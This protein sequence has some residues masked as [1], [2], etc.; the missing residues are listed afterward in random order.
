ML[1]LFK[2]LEQTGVKQEF[3]QHYHSNWNLQVAQRLL[4]FLAQK[5]I[6]ISLIELQ[7]FLGV[8]TQ[9]PTSSTLM[10]AKPS[11]SVDEFPSEDTES[12][13]FSADA[14]TP[15]ILKALPP[16]SNTQHK[17]PSQQSPVADFPG[18]AGLEDLLVADSSEAITSQDLPTVDS[19][20][21]DIT[22]SVESTKDHAPSD[23][24]QA[25]D[26]SSSQNQPDVADFNEYDE[27]DENEY[28]ELGATDHDEIEEDDHNESETTDHNAMEENN[29]A[30]NDEVKQETHNKVSSEAH[31]NHCDFVPPHE[32]GHEFSWQELETISALDLPPPQTAIERSHVNKLLE[33]DAPSQD[34]PEPNAWSDLEMMAPP[35]QSNDG[36]PLDHIEKQ[37]QVVE[38]DLSE[39]NHLAVDPG[40]SSLPDHAQM[41]H[42]QNAMFS[43]RERIP[44]EFHH[45]DDFHPDWQPGYDKSSHQESNMAVPVALSETEILACA[46]CEILPVDDTMNELESANVSEVG[47]EAVSLTMD[48]IPSELSALSTPTISSEKEA[49]LRM[50]AASGVD[51]DKTHEEIVVL[52]EAKKAEEWLR[53]GEFYNALVIYQKLSKTNPNFREEVEKIQIKMRLLEEYLMEAESQLQANSTS[54]AAWYLAQAHDISPQSEKLK[55]LMAELEAHHKEQSAMKQIT[56]AKAKPYPPHLSPTATT[57][58]TSPKPSE[59]STLVRTDRTPETPQPFSNQANPF[60]DSGLTSHFGLLEKK[61]AMAKNYYQRAKDLEAAGQYEEALARLNQCLELVPDLPGGQEYR[62][63][64]ERIV[65]G[66]DAK[67]IQ[68]LKEQGEQFWNEKRFP[69]A[70]GAWCSLL[71]LKKHDLEIEEKVAKAEQKLQDAMELWERAKF[72]IDSDKSQEA[73]QLIQECL[74]IYPYHGNALRML[75]KKQQEAAAANASVI[76]PHLVVPQGLETAEIRTQIDNAKNIRRHTQQHQQRIFE[77]RKRFDQNYDRA[78][79]EEKQKHYTVALQII[80]EL[81]KCPWDI[82]IPD[83]SLDITRLQS[84]IQKSKEDPSISSTGSNAAQELQADSFPV[85][86]SALRVTQVNDASLG[87][88]PSAKLQRTT[89]FFP[90]TAIP[91]GPIEKASLEILNRAGDAIQWLHIE[92]A[93]RLLHEN[94]LSNQ[95]DP[96]VKEKW[97]ITFHHCLRRS[98]QRLWMR[99]GLAVGLIIILAIF[100]WLGKIGLDNQQ[101]WNDYSQQLE[102]DL[103]QVKQLAKE[104][105]DTIPTVNDTT[106]DRVQQ[107]CKNGQDILQQSKKNG[108]LVMVLGLQG[109]G[110][111]EQNLLT[112]VRVLT[113]EMRQKIQEFQLQQLQNVSQRRNELKKHVE[114]CQNSLNTM[115]QSL[116]QLQKD[117]YSKTT[118]IQRQYRP[119]FDRFRQDVLKMQAST[120]NRIQSW[121]LYLQS[122]EGKIDMK[123]SESFPKWMQELEKH[124]KEAQSIYTKIEALQKDIGELQS[125]IKNL[126]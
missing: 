52:P 26:S 54:E 18:G 39:L 17:I 109:T 57:E 8:K 43:I 120:P 27:L 93:E 37:E 96:T 73:E 62:S 46:F 29:D 1:D 71:L 28:D 65:Q 70:I 30:K 100:Q 87:N 118:K 72:L 119:K 24:E 111:Q 15:A 58:K 125:E 107:A 19:S 31:E 88:V 85:L 44:E 89:Q 7:R 67:E 110:V 36:S 20:H 35:E 66:P 115:I 83:L 75:Q 61:I 12:P 114:Q 122:I 124:Q 16:L 94:P 55:K 14:S 32:G 49:F 47:L 77:Q 40:R 53:Q 97:Q 74:K 2:V 13:W 76:A 108:N 126:K 5:N 104:Y 22:S 10:K 105:R 117:L 95:F 59:Q 90:E 116:N 21:T 101:S 113:Q 34:M 6:S 38:D 84:L 23:I 64:L 79:L 68:R 9:F 92:E 51:L 103:E 41:K 82:D 4:K 45:L 50:A 33:P 91:A 63:S 106:I 121:Q 42:I 98:Q 80:Q 81:K 3:I 60:L 25:G 123:N 48:E 112:E 56:E 99:L 69:E 86:N 102:A 11:D 78:K